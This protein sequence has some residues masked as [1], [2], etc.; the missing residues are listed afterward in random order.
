MPADSL[1]AA[2]KKVTNCQR[3]RAKMPR[4]RTL[5]IVT[6]HRAVLAAFAV[7]LSTF[8]LPQLFAVLLSTFLCVQ[9]LWQPDAARIY[10]VLSFVLL[11]SHPPSTSRI[12][13]N[14]CPSR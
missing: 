2:P 13:S 12:Y 10:C 14:Y 5:V 1:F 7:P 8:F 9:L 3:V 4:I 11:F 6:A